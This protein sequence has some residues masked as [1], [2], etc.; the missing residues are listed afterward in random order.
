MT[1]Q[2]QIKAQLERSG[3]P[4]KEIKVFGSQIIVISWS[5]DA[6]DKWA[7]LIA[8]F[9]TVRGVVESVDYNKENRNTVLRPTKHKVWLT[10]ARI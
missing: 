1:I 3:I 9:A 2:E 8:K 4:H 10:G 6:A 7:R 5:R